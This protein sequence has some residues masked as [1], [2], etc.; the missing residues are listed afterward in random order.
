[1]LYLQCPE[2]LVDI[3]PSC[4]GYVFLSLQNLVRQ[5]MLVSVSVKGPQ[6]LLTV[7]LDRQYHSK[8]TPSP[9]TRTRRGMTGG[10]AFRPIARP[11]MR[12]NVN[13]SGKLGLIRFA[14][15]C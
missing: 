3:G 5:E 12:R 4:A 9:E 1:M 2:I 6:R 15:V 11:A 13:S 8:R 7:L 10:P 14:V